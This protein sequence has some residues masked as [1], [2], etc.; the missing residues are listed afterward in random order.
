MI[1]FLCR[2][3]RKQKKQKAFNRVFFVSVPSPSS[4]QRALL[5]SIQN[6]VL[7]SLARAAA[8]RLLASQ[9][10]QMASSSSSTTA[11]AAAAA[12]LVSRRAFSASAAAS[13]DE[14]LIEHEV[15]S[16]YRSLAFELKEREKGRREPAWRRLWFFCGAAAEKP[17]HRFFFFSLSSRHFYQLFLSFSAQRPSE[18]LVFMTH[19]FPRTK[20]S[21]EKTIERRESKGAQTGC[22]FRVFQ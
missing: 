14:P 22:V 5:Q 20:R 8:A 2:S 21:E 10:Q 17:H 12:A 4:P 11:A 9:Q 7:G 18:A 3:R 6:M 15:S 1:H 19:S 16:V 13:S